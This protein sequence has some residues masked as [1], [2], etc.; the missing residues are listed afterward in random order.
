MKEN[1][2]AEEL[3]SMM[4]AQLDC[5]INIIAQGAPGDWNATY[6]GSSASTEFLKKFEDARDHY[7]SIYSLAPD[8]AA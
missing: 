7:R 6:A 3:K 5:S 4:K 2:T 8:R 1:K